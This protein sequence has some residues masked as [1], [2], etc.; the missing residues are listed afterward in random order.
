[1]GLDMVDGDLAGFSSIVGVHIPAY[2][3]LRDIWIRWSDGLAL[4]GANGAGKSNLL[5]A[6]ALLLGTEETLRRG[7]HRFDLRVTGLSVVVRDDQ[8]HMPLPP[9]GG[10]EIRFPDVHPGPWA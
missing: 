4:L 6:I 8:E 10:R 9:D 5:E 7:R 2:K 1:M 3:N